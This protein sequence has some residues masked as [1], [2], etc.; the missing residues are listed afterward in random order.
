MFK[1]DS[2]IQEQ[3]HDRS[4]IYISDMNPETGTVGR[5]ANPKFAMFVGLVT[6][7]CPAV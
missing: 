6:I 4:Q 7:Q 2:S 5:A 1:S 3:L